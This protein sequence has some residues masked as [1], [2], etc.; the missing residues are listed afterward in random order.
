MILLHYECSNKSQNALCHAMPLPSPCDYDCETKHTKMND[1]DCDCDSDCNCKWFA[2]RFWRGGTSS[3]YHLHASLNKIEEDKKM[4]AR[5]IYTHTPLWI[6][7][8]NDVEGGSVTARLLS[9]FDS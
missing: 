6:E 9:V 5:K 2:F 4:K 1:C 7:A 3:F 8:N